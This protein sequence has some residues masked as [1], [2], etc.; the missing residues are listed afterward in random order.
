MRP[1]GGLH[2]RLYSAPQPLGSAMNDTPT[3]TRSGALL[4]KPLSNAQLL[5]RRQVATHLSIVV[6]CYNE[7]EVLPETAKRL[8]E[9][10]AKMVGAGKITA[11]SQVIL[12]DDGSRDRTWEV[13]RELHDANPQ[14]R[15]VKL[16]GNRG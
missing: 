3:Q 12:V 2:G 15:G 16:S 13:I 14:I 1:S 9:L 4:E 6:P 10:L 7:E 5:E 8:R 11:E